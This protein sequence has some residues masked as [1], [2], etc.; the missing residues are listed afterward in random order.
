MSNEA[1]ERLR[2]AFD[3]LRHGHQPMYNGRPSC[4][5]C[6]SFVDSE[7]THAPGC[8]TTTSVL[9]EAL[10]T[11]RRM[12]VDEIRNGLWFLNPT[13]QAEA[14]KV[15]AASLPTKGEDR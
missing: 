12:M 2:L 3:R 1:A 14:N 11:E 15:L 10:A 9:D 6:G 5:L 7:E 8:L 4:A 13:Q